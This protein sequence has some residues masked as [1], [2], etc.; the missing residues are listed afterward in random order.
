MTKHNK[1][2]GFEIAKGYEE[3]DIR[4]P[5]RQTTFAAGYDFEA[6]EDVTIPSI[7]QVLFNKLLKKLNSEENLTEEDNQLLK[8]TLV[9]TGVKAYMQEDEVLLVFSRSSGPIKRFLLLSNGTGVVD[10]DF[11]SNEKDDGDIKLQFLNFG[12]L[13]VKIKK[14]ER[15]GQ[16]MF[17]KYLLTDYDRAKGERK[18]GFGST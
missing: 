8:P 5:I 6:A 9:P 18:G 16:G 3:R 10:K 2:R 7:F 13:P 17:Q 4:L 12:I 11:Y 14:G 1:T 15:I